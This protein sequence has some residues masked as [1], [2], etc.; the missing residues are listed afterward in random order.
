[1]NKSGQAGIITFLA[2]MVGLFILAPVVLK[3]SNSVLGGFS[4]ALNDTSQEASQRIDYVH[5]TFV[6]FWDWVIAIAFFTNVIMLFVFA[7]MVDSHPIFALFYFISAAITLMFSNTILAPAQVIFGTEALSTEILQLPVTGFIV[8]AFNI[9]L[10][11][12]IFVT[13]V[14][15]YGKFR[16]GGLQR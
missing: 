9:I 12:I 1:M 3:I 4:D 5:D 7:F 6:G 14:I 13:G 8:N 11:G 16:G 10:L 15:M 2:L